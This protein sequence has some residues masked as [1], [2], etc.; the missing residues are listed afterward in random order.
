MLLYAVWTSN[1][2]WLLIVANT[3]S[4]TGFDPENPR[5]SEG[6]AFDAVQTY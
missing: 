3:Q 2:K 5:S 1:N 6:T 4:D